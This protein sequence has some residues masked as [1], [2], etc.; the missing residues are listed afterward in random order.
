MG[1]FDRTQ[2]ALPANLYRLLFTAVVSTG[3]GAKTFLP[4]SIPNLKF[5]SLACYL[6]HFKAKVNSYGWKVVVYKVVITE[7]DKQR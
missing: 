5:T 2:L 1:Q 6:E 3:N 4:C 7:A